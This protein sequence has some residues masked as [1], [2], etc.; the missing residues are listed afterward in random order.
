[1]SLLK[2]RFLILFTLLAIALPIFLQLG[3][4][5]LNEPDEGRYSEMGREMLVT[6][7][8]LVP[9]LNGVPHYAKPP[10]IYWC[11]ATSFKIFGL[12]E[13]AARLPTAVA[14]LVTALTVFAL[15]RRMAGGLAGLCSALVLVTSLLFFAC[16]RLITP[17]MMLTAFITLAVY[18]FWRWR[19]SGHASRD[20][21]PPRMGWLVGF[22]VA[23][24]F[25]FFD[26]GP[27]GI[28][29]PLAAVIPFLL[30][31]KETA[32]LRKMGWIWGFLIVAAIALPWFIW[33]CRTNPD[34]YD[35]YLRGEIQARVTSG[36]GRFKPLW[37]FLAVLPL[38]C[39]PW[40]VL[41]FPA[42]ARIQKNAIT[43]FL[44]CWWIVPFIIYSAVPSKLPTYILPVL[45]PIALLIGIWMAQCLKQKESFPGWAAIA[46]YF[47]LAVL[48]AALFR[49][50]RPQADSIWLV[51]TAAVVFI[52]PIFWLLTLRSSGW[53][54]AGWFAMAFLLV[55]SILLEFPKMETGFG[56]N[57][58]WRD[59][60]LPLQ[61]MDLVGVPIPT[62]LHPTGKKPEF[63]RAGPRVVMYEFYFRSSSFYL[64]RDKKEI[65]P[66]YGGDSIWEN[67]KDKEAEAKPIRAD[68]IE[69]LK[70]PEPVF[71]FTRP[72]YLKELRDLTGM[73][74][75][76]RLKV[77]SG[78]NQ[79]VLFSNRE[80]GH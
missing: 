12:H 21:S 47:L 11:I 71:V 79:V 50:S 32:S 35:F 2:K 49:F 52:S 33:M 30:W 7:D 24:G 6:G 23:M 8:W 40:T 73:T 65:V 9:R 19:E 45:V 43:R 80:I 55:Q 62:G 60:T 31:Q 41:L 20:G 77:A 42:C 64:M 28:I 27:Y 53:R 76:L 78:E 74:L 15:G 13:W 18:C 57:S 3:G 34:L 63:T 44:F 17:D 46:T 56:H 38:A 51:W 37:Y 54:L 61:G 72:Q 75:P 5:G 69:L 29:I 67:E 26:K 14:A 25:G 59:L 1:M 66:L 4:R 39:W 22:Y 48:P 70:G 36:R 10:W 58:S 68:L 16:G